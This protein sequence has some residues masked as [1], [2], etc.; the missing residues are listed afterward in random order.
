MLLLDR[1]GAVAHVSW[2]SDVA[3]GCR[4]PLLKSQGGQINLSQEG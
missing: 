2:D 1:L 3:N 4:K